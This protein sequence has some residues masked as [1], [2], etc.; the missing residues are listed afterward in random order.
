MSTCTEVRS[1]D[2]EAPVVVDPFVPQLYRVISR[3]AETRD[4]VTQALVPLNGALPRS[5]PGQFNMLSALGVGEVAISIS[6]VEDEDAQLIHT[7]RSVGPVSKALAGTEV[8][9]VIGVRGPFG[10]DWGIDQVGGTDVVVI[11]GGIGLA[12]LKRVI[13][14]LLERVRKGSGQLFVLV[15]ARSPDDVVF[16]AELAAWRA[17]GA[18]VAVTV[19]SAGTDWRGPVGLITTLIP[20]A[21]FEADRAIAMMCGPEI[22]MR[23][24]ARA[25]L[26]RG[27]ETSRIRVSLERNMQCGVGL[28]GHCQLGPLLLCRDG[29]IVTY[30][31]AVPE[32]MARREL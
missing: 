23:F 13:T 29:P 7:I 18:Y 12:P 8:G 4:V 20:D 17:A 28:C 2:A 5:R 6:G 14:A 31:G 32:L 22:M 11:A 26:D 3:R 15:G 16:R 24:S 30:D 9:G 10:T 27:I 1:D 19:D 25:L 21:P